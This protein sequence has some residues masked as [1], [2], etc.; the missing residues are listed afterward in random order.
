MIIEA[1]DNFTEL[2]GYIWDHI[3]KIVKC[4]GTILVMVA[5]PLGLMF[6]VMYLWPPNLF[7]IPIVVILF[8]LT[9]VLAMCAIVAA[10]TAESD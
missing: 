3:G 7:S 4:A 10:A 1:W 9:L 5:V 8:V 2:L 6:L